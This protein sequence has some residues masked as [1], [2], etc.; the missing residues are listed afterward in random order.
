VHAAGVGDA[1]AKEVQHAQLGEGRD[2]AQAGVAEQAVVKVQL[3][4]ACQLRYRCQP[5][6]PNARC[7]ACKGIRASTV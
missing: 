4:Q 6:V 2:G 1:R 5:K 3:T 7:S